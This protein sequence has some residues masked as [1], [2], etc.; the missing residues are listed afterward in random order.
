MTARARIQRYRDGTFSPR[1]DLVAGE[2]P[3]EIRLGGESM[4]VTMRTAGHDI[5]LAHGLLHAEGIIATAADVVAMRYCDGVDEQGRNTYNVLDVQLAGPVPVA[6]RSGARAFVT[7]SACGVC[8]SASIDQLKLRT[9]HAL[10]ATLHFDPDVLCAAP[11]QLRSHQKAFAGTGGIHGAA[12]LSPDG[13]LRLVR[14]DIGR[15]NAVDKVIGA[16]LLAGDVPLGGEA[17]LTSSRAS[18]ELVQKAVMAGIGMLIAVSAP[19]SLAVELAAETGL[20][21]IGFTRD[22]GFNLY[23]GADRV[24]GAA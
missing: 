7:S 24:I 21:L 19:S 16:A 8:G 11:D 17:L 4:S 2:E 22:H 5:E 6:A 23:S 10:P 20:T 3:L 18:F 15:H 12:L 13:S 14:E 9:R 1:A